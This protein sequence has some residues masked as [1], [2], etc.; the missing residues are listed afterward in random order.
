[1][2]RGKVYKNNRSS[3]AIILKDAGHYWLDI[4]TEDIS[5]IVAGIVRT[6]AQAEQAGA[7]NIEEVKREMPF[8][9]Y[10]AIN[11][12]LRQ[13]GTKDAVFAIAYLDSTWNLICRSEN[14]G[15]VCH[16]H[17]IWQLDAL[18]IHF[19]HEKVN[20]EGDSRKK[21]PRHCYANPLDPVVCMITSV[22]DFIA[23]FL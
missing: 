20:Q 3:I 8:E 7:G 18:G 14:T 6:V 2:M 12:W 15:T 9:L 21:K 13:R 4:S 5:I 22:F 16:K 19:A 23:C 10:R 11:K 17:L 1:M